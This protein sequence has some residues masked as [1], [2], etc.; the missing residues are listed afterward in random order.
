MDD[1]IPIKILGLG[2]IGVCPIC[3]GEGQLWHCDD[4]ADL[5]W[6]VPCENCGGIGQMLGMPQV[7]QDEVPF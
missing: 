2:V 1:T 3:E 7:D 4:E 6:K 5:Q